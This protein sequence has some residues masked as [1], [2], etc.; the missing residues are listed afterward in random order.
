MAA[1]ID[2]TKPGQTASSR[3]TY[4]QLAFAFAFLLLGAG[5][6]LLYIQNYRIDSDEPQHL[7]VVWAWSQGLL[8]YRDVFDNHSPLFQALCAPVFHYLGERADIVVPMRAAELPLYFLSV[9]CVWRI[10]TRIWSPRIALWIAV[11]TAIFPPWFLAAVEFRPDQLWTLCWLLI[12]LV[13]SSTPFRIKH[14]FLVGVLLGVSFC[15]SMKSTLF[16]LALTQAVAATLIFQRKTEGAAIP[17][18]KLG[19]HAAVILVG[20]TILPALTALYFFRQGIMAD[21]LYGIIG[22]NVLPGSAGHA[23]GFSA[24]ARWLI[25]V[26]LAVAMGWALARTELDDS[27]RKRIVLLLFANWFFIVSLFAFWPVITM[28]DHLPWLACTMLFVVP[29][30]FRLGA[31]FAPRIV[32]AAGVVLA[33]IEILFLLAMALPWQDN[34]HDKIGMV[35]DTLKLTTPDEFV[36]DSKGETI[37]RRRPFRYVLESRTFQ[38]LD[39]GLIVDDI[40]DCMVRTRTPLATLRRMPP[41]ARTFIRANYVAIAYRLRVAGKQVRNNPTP[42]GDRCAFE[43]IVPQRYMLITP[44]GPS[45]GT[46]DGIPL[47]GPRELAAGT[48]MFIPSKDSEEITL[49]WARALEVGYSPFAEIKP[50]ITT[51]QD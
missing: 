23:V 19:S 26:G 28:E 11:L 29:I 37:Y 45:E 3:V 9:L 40:A 13:A 14:A 50:S 2:D 38:R 34:A 48:H 10:A 51:A 35:A 46:L 15:V 22:H 7:H 42:A 39:N 25:G 32:P 21:F 4:W 41:A 20:A 36:M 27:T 24:I 8:P 12:L 43:V 49:I 30:L 17:W 44:G 6:R 47:D 1:T 31:T 5:L 16:A 18:K 33:S